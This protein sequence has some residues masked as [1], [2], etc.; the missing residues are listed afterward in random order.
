MI[1]FAWRFHLELGSLLVALGSLLKALGIDL[2]EYEDK[3]K[4]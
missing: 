3:W 2:G 1:V 4:K